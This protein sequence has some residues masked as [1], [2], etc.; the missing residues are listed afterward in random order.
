M[1]TVMLVLSI[2]NSKTGLRENK[3]VV[4]NKNAFIRFVT[5]NRKELINVDAFKINN[6]T[7]PDK[8]NTQLS[9]D[10]QMYLEN[11]IDLIDELKS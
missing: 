6:T 7:I 3:A 9:F 4:N 11:L 8:Y 1:V 5:E 10:E 2:T